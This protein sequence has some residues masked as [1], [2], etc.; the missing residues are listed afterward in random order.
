MPPPAPGYMMLSFH[1][2]GRDTFLEKLNKQLKTQP[3]VDKAQEEVRQF[4]AQAAGI[5]LA[6]FY[7]F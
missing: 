5:R 6:F 3:W 4:S 1:S 7:V 2:S